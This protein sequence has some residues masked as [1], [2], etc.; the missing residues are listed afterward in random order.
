MMACWSPPLPAPPSMGVSGPNGYG[1]GSLSDAYWKVMLTFGWLELVTTNGM[2]YGTEVPESPKS[3]W[4]NR[5]GPPVLAI[6]AALCGSTGSFLMSVFQTLFAGNT[7]HPAMPGPEL[8]RTGGAVVVVV[9]DDRG[10]ELLGVAVGWLWPDATGCAVRAVVEVVAAVLVEVVLVDV[11]SV[12]PL[13]MPS[14]RLGTAARGGPGT[15]PDVHEE[16]RRVAATPATAAVHR[17]DLFGIA[18][19][20]P[21]SNTAI[22]GTIRRIETLVAGC[23]TPEDTQPRPGHL[24]A[25]RRAPPDLYEWSKSQP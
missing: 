1:P 13:A 5:L 18:A 10:A 23:V 24:N 2:P 9:T 17:L 6:Q 19:L 14:P 4:I 12:V 15:G 16:A 8:G 3:G 11:V 7:G 20:G 22:G 25:Y 21:Y